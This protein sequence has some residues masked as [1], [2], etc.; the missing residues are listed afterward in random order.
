MKRLLI[1]AADYPYPPKGGAQRYVFSVSRELA[2]SYEVTLLCLNRTGENKPEGMDFIHHIKLQPFPR[3]GLVQRLKEIFLPYFFKNYRPEFQ[4]QINLE[5]SNHD[6]IIFDH[7]NTG[8]YLKNLPVINKPIA[9]FTHNVEEEIFEDYLKHQKFGLRKILSSIQRISLYSLQKKIY[10]RPQFAYCINPRDQKVLAERY[11]RDFSVTPNGVDC[12]NFAFCKNE[13][14]EDLL[15]VGNLNWGQNLYGLRWFL[16]KAFEKTGKPLLIVG[17]SG[18]PEQT[19]AEFSGK[20]REV[21]ISP[22]ELT[23]YY[24][25]SFASLAPI[26]EGGGTRGK[27]LESFAYGVPV[28]STP[29][30]ITG[31]AVEDGEHLLLFNS[32]EELI[33]KLE[34]LKKDK[35]L[36]RKL[37]RNGREYV[38]KNHDWPQIAAIYRQGFDSL[39]PK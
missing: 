11:K 9:F 29:L 34:L 26:F 31:L 4:E 32:P 21:H 6:F 10:S 27:I 3:A 2:K 5:A 22:A 36:Y 15:F 38:E 17:H 23:P 37:A 30:G 7:M 25:R 13:D 39:N 24:Q 33:E 35:E 28:L 8:L 18:S 20:N 1:V 16:D 12:Q 19:L 14:Q